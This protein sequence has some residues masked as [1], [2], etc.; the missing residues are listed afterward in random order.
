MSVIFDSELSGLTD[1][2]HAEA[3]HIAAKNLER[4]CWIVPRIDEHA[5]QCQDRRVAGRCK[6]RRGTCV[7]DQLGANW[8]SL[9][10]L[11]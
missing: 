5:S 8:F 6:P 10:W 4:C 11:R 2:A 1:R 7:A 3:Q 9:R